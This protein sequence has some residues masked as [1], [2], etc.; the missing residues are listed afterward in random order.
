MHQIF[1][2]R[3]VH[4][5]PRFIGGNIL[6]QN[7]ITHFINHPVERRL[8]HSHFRFRL[9]QNA[10]EPA[11]GADARGQHPRGPLD[12]HF[13]IDDEI[14]LHPEMR[15]GLH[16]IRHDR[17]AQF[18][19]G[20]HHHII[21]RGAQARGAPIDLDNLR[22]DVRLHAVLMNHNPVAHFEWPIHV[23]RQAHK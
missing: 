23:N 17:F 1:K 9:G 18:A 22:D 12:G 14:Q 7:E 8:L 19:V 15:R 13:E 5:M 21:C 4:L 11:R 3:S 10:L 6:W 20:H 16:I 2:H